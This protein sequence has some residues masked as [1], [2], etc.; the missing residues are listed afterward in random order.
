MRSDYSKIEAG[1]VFFAVWHEQWDANIQHHA[2]QG[3]IIQVRG[4]VGK[5]ET[6]LLQFNCF[7]I[8]RTYTYAPEGKAKICQIDPIADGNPIGWMARQI[9]D[10]LPEML[11][12]GGF[13]RIADRLDMKKVRNAIVDVES[14]ARNK[15]RNSIQL[16]KQDDFELLLPKYPIPQLFLLLQFFLQP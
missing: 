13:N 11:N 9:S 8:E 10:R 12:A 3:V 14:E 7:H 6:N 5:K 2:D 16:V 15:F 1:N 4:K